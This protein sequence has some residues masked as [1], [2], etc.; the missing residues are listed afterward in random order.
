MHLLDTVPE[1]TSP[2]RAVDARRD[3]DLRADADLL[4]R[5]LEGDDGALREIVS[6]YGALVHGLARRVTG[7]EAE[8]ADIAQDVFVRL[9]ER[10]DRV[11]LSRGSLRTYLGVVAH[12]R[13]LDVLRSAGRSRRR[14]ERLGRE[15][16][17]TVPSHEATVVEDA[18]AATQAER[19]RLALGALPA[20]QRAALDLAYFGGCTYREV[21]TRL[22]IPEG[23]AKSRLRIALARLRELLA[24]PPGPVDRGSP[25][26]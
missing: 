21:A 23:T 2:G 16:G 26:A 5:L 13:A 3:D 4:A 22:G 11:D 10:P 14:E 15:E 8:A 7:S 24:D 12:R 25:D 17:V 18:H 1:R 9:W 19:L 6:A 20:E